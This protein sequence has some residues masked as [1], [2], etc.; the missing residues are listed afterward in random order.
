MSQFIQDFLWFTLFHVESPIQ[1]LFFQ[2]FFTWKLELPSTK[3]D[4]E[5]N[6]PFLNSQNKKTITSKFTARQQTII[7]FLI[8][9]SQATKAGNF[10]LMSIFVIQIQRCLIKQTTGQKQLL[11]SFGLKQTVEDNKFIIEGLSA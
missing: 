7:I 11:H 4:Y 5:Q 10:K 1:Y 6:N 8:A 2:L 9:V 3:V